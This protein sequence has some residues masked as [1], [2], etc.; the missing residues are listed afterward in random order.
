M[1]NLFKCSVRVCGSP[2]RSKHTASTGVRGDGRSANI[3]IGPLSPGYSHK[4]DKRVARPDSVAGYNNSKF[5]GDYHQGKH[6]KTLNPLSPTVKNAETESEKR[7]DERGVNV[8]FKGGV[9]SSH[10]NTGLQPV[11]APPPLPTPLSL[12]SPESGTLFSS[13]TEPRT[14]VTHTPNGHYFSHSHNG[15]VSN[16]SPP[17]KEV[18]NLLSPKVQSAAK[19]CQT[20][21][22]NKTSQENNETAVIYENSVDYI[23]LSS[24][25]TNSNDPDKENTFYVDETSSEGSNEIVNVEGNTRPLRRP[26]PL[27]LNSNP[28]YQS[29]ESESSS[30]SNSSFEYKLHTP[31]ISPNPSCFSN[32]DSSRSTFPIQGYLATPSPISPNPLCFGNGDSSRSPS[33]IQGYL[34]TPSPVSRNS[35]FFGNDETDISEIPSSIQGGC[36]TPSSLRT[37]SNNSSG[38]E[39]SPTKEQSESNRSNVLTSPITTPA[40]KSDKKTT[41]LSSKT[42]G[43]ARKKFQEWVALNPQKIDGNHRG[44]M[45]SQVAV[46]ETK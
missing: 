6:N 37:I 29:D 34:P 27:K 20:S 41:E 26:Y 3:N 14:F 33:P 18:Q 30:G 43:A 13:E 5:S 31:P 23:L 36:A 19:A 17:V 28:M 2:S 44:P 35:S 38:W 32:G 21:R 8:N 45:K 1:N 16:T 9:Y 15:S 10:P 12:Q 40:K 24:K 42:F 11:Q 39:N 46:S 22:Q 25:K 4:R 7:R